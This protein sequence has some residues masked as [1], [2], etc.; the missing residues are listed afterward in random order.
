[1]NLTND[2]APA[3]S[4]T[5][6]E[7]AARI[8]GV[9]LTPEDDGYDEER[10]GYQAGYSHRPSVI[11]GAAS[12]ADVVAA[13]RYARSH[14]LLVSVQ[15]TGHGLAAATDGGLLISTRRMDEVRVDA[16]ART[17]WAG[18][19]VLCG[20]V[21]EEAAPYGLA[22]VNGSSPGVGV[23]GFTLGGGLGILGREFGY[24]SD[25]VRAVELVTADGELRRVSGACEPELF[26]ALL[27]GG[28]GLGVVTGLKFGLVP[29][30][31]VY[32]GQLVFG[33]DLVDEVLAVYLAWTEDLP[34]ALTSSVGL[35][36]YPDVPA[37]P[38]HLR[39]RYL[40]HIRIAY[41][42]TAGD[43]ERLVAPLRA[44]GPRVADTLRDM[45]Y[46]ESHTIHQDPTTPHAYDGDSVLLSGLDA[47]ALRAVA[48]LTGP[49]APL[50]TVV[51]L[52]HLGGALAQGGGSVG[53]RDARYLL[54]LLS[55]LDGTDVAAAR[56]LHAEVRGV[57]AP[58]A[59][60]RSVNFLF[61]DHGDKAAD[62]YEEP[63]RRRLAEAKAT[64]DPENL[65]RA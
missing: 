11:V 53:H 23:V 60:G 58:W 59:V 19:G 7:L 25:H 50:M 4:P 21:V 48:A 12:A 14:G 2:T 17:A 18:A 57:P 45:P 52:N 55:P 16:E 28:H 32:G 10:S 31:R 13:V 40:A 42:G 29:V 34:D 5:L 39:G 54:R 49:D 9:V 37:M 62:A 46:A 64:Y 26:R 20:Q 27:G 38:P 33:A 61:G 35:I 56:A 15:S 63:V 65:F 22:P 30:E 8:T 51:Q 43:G 6:A 1:M 41:T 47:D 44:V 24:A 36:A 3:A